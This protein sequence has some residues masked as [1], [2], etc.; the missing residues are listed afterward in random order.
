MEPRLT[1]YQQL[2]LGQ[3]TKA[4]V[5]LDWHSTR[6][7]IFLSVQESGA[8]TAANGDIFE[9]SWFPWHLP[10]GR[11]RIQKLIFLPATCCFPRDEQERA[12]SGLARGCWMF[13]RQNRLLLYL[14]VYHLVT[15]SL[16]PPDCQCMVLCKWWEAGHLHGPY[17]SGVVCGRWLYP[18]LSSES[19]VLRVCQQWRGCWLGDRNLGCYRV[20]REWYL[21]PTSRCVHCLGEHLRQVPVLNEEVRMLCGKRERRALWGWTGRWFGWAQVNLVMFLNTLFRGHQTC[22]HWLSWQ[23]LSSLGLWNR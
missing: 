9:P 5:F 14:G 23:Q 22:P 11:R 7:F 4:P 1:Y 17:W 20:S 6:P 16:T 18:C 2:P 19:H 12:E 13:L 8:G 10:A 15:L 21:P 3:D